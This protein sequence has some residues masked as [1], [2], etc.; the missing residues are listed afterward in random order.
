MVSSFFNRFTATR[1]RPRSFQLLVALLVLF[2]VFIIALR[3]SIIL[4]QIL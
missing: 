4:K 3:F 2:N 1:N